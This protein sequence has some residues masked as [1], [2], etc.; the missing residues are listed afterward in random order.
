MMETRAIRLI[1]TSI[2]FARPSQTIWMPRTFPGPQPPT[3]ICGTSARSETMAAT[4]QKSTAAAASRP[5]RRL[6]PG[7]WAMAT[8]AKAT[9]SGTTTNKGTTA[10]M[11]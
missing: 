9:P 1:V 2:I 4:R 11:V 3:N 5:V 6:R 8:M 10:S 7:M